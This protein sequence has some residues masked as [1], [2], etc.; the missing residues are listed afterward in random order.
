MPENKKGDKNSSPYLSNDLNKQ[1]RLHHLT[2]S[3]LTEC[4]DSP[5]YNQN[6]IQNKPFDMRRGN[7]HL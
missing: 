5:N 6:I 4:Q 7:D 1:A 2:K 3:M